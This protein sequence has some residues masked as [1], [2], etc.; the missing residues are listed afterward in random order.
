VNIRELHNT[1]KPRQNS[2]ML[3]RLT[4]NPGTPLFR[5]HR[6]SS[7]D[8]LLCPVPAALCRTAV[9]FCLALGLISL[10]AQSRA[11]VTLAV[12]ASGRL[13]GFADSEAPKYLSQR[14]TSM[15]LARWRFEPAAAG[16]VLSPDRVEWNFMMR[17]RAGGGV[18]HL[19]RDLRQFGARRPITIQA[20]LFLNGAC[21]NESRDEAWIEGGPDDPDLAAAISQVARSLLESSVRSPCIKSETRSANPP[22][23]APPDK[24]AA[25]QSSAGAGEIQGFRRRYVASGEWR[26]LR[27]RLEERGVSIGISWVMEGFD[28]FLGGIKRGAVGASTFD[29]DLSVDTKKLLGLPNGEFYF[30]LEDHAGRDPSRV[31]TGDLQVF[32][33]LSYTPYFEIFELWYQQRLFKDKLRIKIG[34]VDANTEFSV[35]DNG[36]AFLNSS[37]QVTPTLFVMPTTPSPMPGI[38]A[39]Y[40]P[41]KP[42]YASFGIFD[43]NRSDRFLNFSGH[44]E[45]N[46]PARHGKLLIGETGLVWKQ[47]LKSENEGNLRLGFWG[48][49]GTFTR[50]DQ[51]AQQGAKGLYLIFDQTLWKPSSE[52]NDRRGVRTF[53]E[54]GRTDRAVSPIYRHFG[55]GFA[56]TGPFRRRPD[57]VAGF[58]LQYARISPQPDLRHNYEL[59]LETFYRIQFT[60]WGSFRPDLQYIVPPAGRYPSA[61]V[62]TLRFEV[63]F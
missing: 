16:A 26:G 62:S 35:V 21:V 15:H 7:G 61:L 34:K 22:S 30:D 37:S 28:N 23:S 51:G 10:Q 5:K 2:W 4:G 39:F 41:A 12:N 54:Y 59:A 17:L 24:G 31:L 43:A 9:T 60:R 50:I 19:N 56:W 1:V 47:F 58:C 40:K 49:T 52:K 57:D 3:S 53:L 27:S 36:L 45:R 29:V 8:R 6:F 11:S 33:K 32:D 46:L 42:F 18:L 63:I 44:P 13:P 14:M 25:V 38:N 48:H 20:M 55:G